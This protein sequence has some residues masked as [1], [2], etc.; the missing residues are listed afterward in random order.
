MSKNAIGGR[1]ALT[2]NYAKLS[3]LLGVEDGTL[4]KIELS[5]D[6]T[7]DHA[8]TVYVLLSDA[9]NPVLVPANTGYNHSFSAVDLATVKVKGTAGD[10]VT[11]IGE[12]VDRLTG[13]VPY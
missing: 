11:I 4:G 1:F 10:Y 2:S 7:L 5:I 9:A 8:A 6:A 13:S 12:Q 3:T